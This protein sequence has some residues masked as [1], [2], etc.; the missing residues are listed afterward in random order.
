MKF[1]TLLISFF[2]L[3]SS[4]AFAHTDHAL[5]EGSLHAFYHATFWILF[6]LVVYKGY[7]WFKNKKS[8]KS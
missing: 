7:K 1:L 3:L 4:Q 5:G 6:A 2:S 8:I